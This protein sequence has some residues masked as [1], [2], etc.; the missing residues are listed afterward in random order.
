MVAVAEDLTGDGDAR[1]ARAATA[2][3]RG[4]RRGRGGVI[5]RR[6]G[7]PDVVEGAREAAAGV[8]GGHGGGAL[9]LARETERSLG[10][11]DAGWLGRGLAG[12]L[13]QSARETSFF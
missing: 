1:D 6:G 13:A 12:W 3:A 7:D 9:V 8:G 4:E 11:S 10:M 5:Y 2:S